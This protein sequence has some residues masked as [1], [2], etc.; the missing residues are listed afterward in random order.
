MNNV[1]LQNMQ[2][3]KIQSYSNNPKE[4]LKWIVKKIP[5]QNVVMGTGFGPPGVVLLD[6]L[7]QITREISVFYIDTDFLF[8][9]TYDLRNKL[10]EKYG[11]NFYNSRI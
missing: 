3:E 5:S 9:Q 11:F 8:D 4:L 2:N 6:I 1:A 10:E 7:F